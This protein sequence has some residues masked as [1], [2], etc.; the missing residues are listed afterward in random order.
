LPP[1]FRYGLTVALGALFALG[2]SPLWNLAPRWFVVVVTGFLLLC[3]SVIAVRRFADFLLIGLMFSIPFAGLTKWLFLEDLDPTVQKAAVFAGAIG[4]G[5]TDFLLAGLYLAWLGRIFVTRSAPLPRLHRL[6]GLALLLVAA[7]VCSLLGAVPSLSL[8]LFALVHLVKHILVYFYVSRHLQAHHLRWF[9]AAV[10]FALLLEAG[11]GLVQHQTGRF[12]GLMIDKGTGEMLDYQATVPGIEHIDRA[13]GTT[14]ASHSLGLY[15]AMLL[16]YPLVLSFS[17]SLGR[18][19]RLLSM[20]FFVLGLAALVIT[21][22]RSAWL[23][24]ALSLSVA[25]AVYLWWGERHVLA[26]TLVLLAALLVPAPW[27]VDVI[28]AR[29]T[30]APAEVLTARFDQFQ[31]ALDVWSHHPLFG[32]G[33]GNYVYAMR[34][35]SNQSHEEDAIVHNVFLLLAAEMGLFGVVAFYGLIAAALSR[36]WG[37]IKAHRDPTCRVAL[38]VLTGLVAY[39]LDGLTD[40]LF[41]EPVVYLMFWFSLGLSVALV[42]QLHDA[43]G[44]EGAQGPAA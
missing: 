21:F 26:W 42:R 30:T 1:A 35:Y 29:F 41:R 44:A 9:L 28:L 22:S 19:L 25:W 24:C 15:L 32:F 39:L 43:G 5:L 27:A 18:P 7:N 14:L 33:A 6:D 13:T 38:A 40:P 37:V 20:A 16:P 3:L 10:F 23:S 11:L 8:G 36:L 34:A 17:R 4:V 12:K 31:V 2:L